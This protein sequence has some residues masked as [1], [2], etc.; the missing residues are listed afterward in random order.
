MMSGKAQMA[1]RSNF[2]LLTTVSIG[3]QSYGTLQHSSTGLSPGAT[4]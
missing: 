3:L 4:Y 2:M 1:A